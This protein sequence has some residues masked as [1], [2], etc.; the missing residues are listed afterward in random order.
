[1]RAGRR[2]LT[3]PKSM[4]RELKV[5]LGLLLE[6]EP[7]ETITRLREMIRRLRPVMFASVGDFSSRNVLEAGLKPDIVVVDQRVMRA[8]VEPLS[9][10]N[11]LEIRTRNPPGTIDA[12]AWGALE[13]AVSLKRGVAVIVEGEEDLLV[14]PLIAS[15]PLGSLIV[16]GQPLLGMVVVEV[17]EA[18]KRWAEGFMRRMEEN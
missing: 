17:T 3:L 11:R 13:E 6:G 15:M 2:T 1:M 5:P 12:E 16:Y 4:R 10:G 18:R 14:L 7:S 9:L 8:C